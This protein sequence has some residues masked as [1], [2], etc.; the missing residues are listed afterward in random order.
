MC[1]QF[2][3]TKILVVLILVLQ[4]SVTTTA[5]T[6]AASAEDSARNQAFQLYDAGKYADALPLL[7]KIVADHPSDITAKEHWAFSMVGYA[8]TLPDPAER[9]KMR[10]RARM[11]AIQLKE[12]GD[13]S[14]LLQ[15]MLDLPEDGSEPSFSDRKD[16]DDAM[17]A[18]EADF[19]R[20]D[21]DKAREGYLHALLLDPRNYNAAL[22]TGDV[23][24]KQLRTIRLGSGSRARSRL[25]RTVRRLTGIGAMPLPLRRRTMRREG[26]SS[27]PWSRN[28][29]ATRLG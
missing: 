2:E 26:N 24:F 18:A 23:Y 9:K 19:G 29:I 28:H 10:A 11:L 21:L 4:F 3:L 22:F 20:G 14:N 16:V 12:A 1:R 6:P 17:R 7:E 8:A 25:I 5:Q 27:T 13:N 15:M